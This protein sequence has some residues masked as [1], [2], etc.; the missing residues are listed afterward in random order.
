MSSEDPIKP[1]ADEDYWQSIRR[2][3]YLDPLHPLYG[4]DFRKPEPDS[5]T[6]ARQQYVEKQA[7]IAAVKQAN[8]GR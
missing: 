6:L 5:L 8:K 3:E 4:L 7:R 2:P 1:D